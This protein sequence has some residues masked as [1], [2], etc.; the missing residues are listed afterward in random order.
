MKRMAYLVALAVALAGCG[1]DDTKTGDK[2]LLNFEEQANQRLGVTTTTK[3]A[4]TSTTAASGPGGKPY[5][6]NGA[7]VPTTAKAT[8][9][10]VPPTTA[11]TAPQATLEIAIRS[12]SAESK[13]DP[14][15]AAVYV[16]SIVRWVNK[17]SVARS[18]QADGGQFRSPMIPPGG[19]FEYKATKEG[20]YNYTDGTRPY[21]IGILQV[22]PK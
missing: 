1:G 4:P 15:N 12:D 20:T 22:L 16:G 8:A 18:I 21:A 2:A 5:S 9:T 7:T 13:F 17:D 6:Q 3:A 14:E 11:T 19:K 10:T